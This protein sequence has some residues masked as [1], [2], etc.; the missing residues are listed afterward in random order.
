MIQHTR[1]GRAQRLKR[2]V[3]YTVLHRLNPEPRKSS[4]PLS[5]VIP[6]VL[7]NSYKKFLI[8]RSR[9]T[10]IDYSKIIIIKDIDTTL[11]PKINLWIGKMFSK[12]PI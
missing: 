6:L 9:L 3:N 12:S 4:P 11:L 7:P 10:H 1:N 8:A 2:L 5:K